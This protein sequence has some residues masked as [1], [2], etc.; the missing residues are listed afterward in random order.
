[1]EEDGDGAM[2]C[3]SCGIAGEDGIKLK[4]CTGCHLVR[5]CSVKCQKDH[6]PKHKR[7]CKRRAAELRD[8]I[9]FKQPESSHYGDC[10]I[11]FLP[12][13]LD[14]EK[15]V[16]HLCC[17][18]R[19]CIGCKI[20][21]SLT[22]VRRELEGSSIDERCPFC[23]KTP[24]ETKEECNDRRMKRIDANDPTAMCFNGTERYYE[25]DY[26]TALEYWT[27]A[28]ALGDAEAHYQL[29]VLYHF[30]ETVEKD[31]KKELHHLE[32]AAIG[33]VPDARHV[34]GCYEEQRGRRD[35]AAKHWIIA[36]KLG[37]DKS[38]ESVKGGYRAGLISK[39]DF[40]TALRGYQA[41]IDATKSSQRKAGAI[42]KEAGY[43][44]F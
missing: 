42:L 18:K 10:L 31:E 41:A 33:G 28:A 43:G 25:G 27:R 37:F 35:R 39:D 20:G 36:A 1:M 13:P 17:S 11:C 5:Y 16:F 34:L 7:E 38:L 4:K 44:N 3:A 15:S 29:S 23:R 6:R 40:A 22:N 14:P 32:E 19:V 21:C 12:L 8:E 30:G 26:K 9:L 2:F 24:P